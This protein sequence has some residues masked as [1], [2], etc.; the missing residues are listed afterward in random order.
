METFHSQQNKVGVEHI[1]LCKLCEEAMQKTK[2]TE[3]HT[4]IRKSNRD[5]LSGLAPQVEHRED[6]LLNNGTLCLYQ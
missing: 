2:C 4:S 3:E 1:I 5:R 6:V